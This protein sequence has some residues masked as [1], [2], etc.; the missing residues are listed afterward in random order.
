MLRAAKGQRAGGIGTKKERDTRVDV[1]AAAL[2]AVHDVN[3][4]LDPLSAVLALD[5]VLLREAKHLPRDPPI[6]RTPLVVLACQRRGGEE[7][8][9]QAESMVL[10]RGGEE[11]RGEEFFP[12]VEGGG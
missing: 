4:A 9:A 12:E 3:V 7:D 11:G 8:S 10:R 5:R 2:D 1:Y 6:Q